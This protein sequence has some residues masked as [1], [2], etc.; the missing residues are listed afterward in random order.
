MKKTVLFL[1]ILIAI[2]AV[3]ANK[4]TKGEMIVLGYTQNMEEVERGSL[5]SGD[6]FVDVQINGHKDTLVMIG[7]PGKEVKFPIKETTYLG[8][9]PTGYAHWK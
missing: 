4:Y 5:F 9:L 7:V 2:L 6:H 8:F 1:V 3:V